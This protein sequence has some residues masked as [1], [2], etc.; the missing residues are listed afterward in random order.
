MADVVESTASVTFPPQH[1]AEQDLGVGGD[2]PNGLEASLAAFG[3]CLMA[4]I[5]AKALARRI[6]VKHVD[7]RLGPDMFV[8]ARWG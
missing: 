3:S 2:A 6:P 1:V 8:T 5:H 4:G 7:V